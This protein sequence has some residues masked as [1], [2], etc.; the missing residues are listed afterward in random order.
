MPVNYP[1]FC[2]LAVPLF[3]ARGFSQGAGDPLLTTISND[4]DLTTF[5]SLFNA[6]GGQSGLPG[7]DLEERFNVPNFGP[8][9]AFAPTN[10]AF[11]KVPDPV[12]ELLTA[13]SSYQLV[14]AI[15]RTHIAKGSLPPDDLN[16][17]SATLVSVEGFQLE[18][19]PQDGGTKIN[20]QAV[21]STDAPLQAAN[22][23]VY[24][25]DRVID[26]FVSYFGDDQNQDNAV[27][28]DNFPGFGQNQDN[29]P[30][31]DFP[32]SDQNQDNGPQDNNSSGKDGND[33]KDAPQDNAA[34]QDGNAPQDA[35][36]DGSFGPDENQQK[37]AAQGQFPDS[38]NSNKDKEAD[39]DNY[40]GP[41]G[42][43]DNNGP[44]DDFSCPDDN[45]D[46]GDQN[47]QNGPDKN[48][49]QDD[50][51]CPDDNQDNGDQNQ[52]NGPNNEDGFSQGG[53]NGTMASI[54]LSDAQLSTLASALQI[55]DPPFVKVLSLDGLGKSPIFF[56]PSNGAFEQAGSSG[57]PQPSNA[58]ELPR[59]YSSA[60]Q[61]SNVD[62]SSLLLRF[63]LVP[64]GIEDGK[65]KSISEFE[66]IIDGGRINNAVVE[67]IECGCNGC[68][69]RV[70][71]WIDPIYRVFDR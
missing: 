44:Q 52:Q 18:F 43:Q 62:F 3:I 39:Q 21:L 4:P 12:I 10:D 15:L 71:R 9:T 38:N 53:C 7:P 45:Q 33:N 67:N 70:S 28:L 58:G 23:I 48:G 5:Y 6:T 35:P 17:G 36:Q 61:P 50:F 64:D 41:D 19:R 27:P 34:G 1:L 11:D 57:S 22:G 40:S 14:L 8:Y 31:E 55:I 20:G 13:A 25:I 42:N 26:P 47:Q 68:V 24:K 29:G 54:L 65:A 49:P 16:N 66:L 69:A 60:V 2:I 32:G 30:Q 63:G 56:A 37:Q 46:K 51:S 59:S